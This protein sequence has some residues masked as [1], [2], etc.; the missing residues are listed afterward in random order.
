[1]AGADNSDHNSDHNSDMA[2]ND[3]L[4]GT[5]VPTITAG[6]TSPSAD[7]TDVSSSPVQEELVTDELLNWRAT[8]TA[9]ETIG[10]A[11]RWYL[12]PSNGQ[13]ELEYLG[14]EKPLGPV[15][16]TAN[17]YLG[18]LVSTEDI[19]PGWYW[20]VVCVSFK[21]VDLDKLDTLRL[22]TVIADDKLNMFTMARMCETILDKDEIQ[23]IPKDDFTRLRLHRQ[24]AVRVF[25]VDTHLAFELVANAGSN[26]S[27]P[28]PSFELHY[29]ELWASDY[30]P[31]DG[32]QDHVVYG[33]DIPDEIIRVGANCDTSISGPI[34][35]KAYDFSASGRHAATIYF[36][37]GRAHIEVWDLQQSKDRRVIGQPYR[38]LEPCARAS[39]PVSADITSPVANYHLDVMI[40]ISSSGSQVATTCIDKA[41]NHFPL[42]F[43]QSSPTA[44]AD[45]D[46]SL[47]W[48]LERVD[49]DCKG[50]VDYYGFGMFHTCDNENSQEENERFFTFEGTSFNVYSTNGAWIQL[51]SLEL[52]QAIDNWQPPAWALFQSLRGCY[53][54][55]TGNRGI[56]TIIDFD[57][58]TIVSNISIPEDNAQVYT[59]FSPDGSKVAISVKGTIQ[60]FDTF[61]GI[62]LGTYKEGLDDNNDFEVVLGHDQF[63]TVNS[64]DS[65]TGD[66]TIH[67]VRRV[68]RLSDMSVVSSHSVH[69]DYTLHFP[70]GDLKFACDQGATLSIKNMPSFDLNL[71]TVEE[72][73][74]GAS[75]ELEVLPFHITYQGWGETFKSSKDETFNLKIVHLFS[76]GDYVVTVNITSQ[77]SDRSA[78]AVLGPIEYDYHMF[79]IPRTSQIVFM[80]HQYLQ[81]WTLSD[82]NPDLCK[83]DYVWQ[84]DTN[85]PGSD[86]DFCRREFLDVRACQHSKQL[87]LTFSPAKWYRSNMEPVERRSM[88]P[89]ILTIPPSPEDTFKT[90]QEYRFSKGLLYIADSYVDSP[91][92]SK[93]VIVRYISSFIR[94]TPEHPTSS[95]LILCR[96][97]TPGGR[98]EFKQL[99]VDLLPTNVITWI[100]EVNI[101]KD[102]CPLAI[103]IE[104]AKS[105]PIVIEAAKVVMDYCVS[106]ANRFKNLVF[107][108]P[109]FDCMH[110]IMELYPNTALD[111]LARM[112]YIPVRHRSFIMDNHIIV[113]PPRVRLQFWKPTRKP[114][115][116]TKDPIMQLHVSSKV[117][118]PLNDKFTHPV[119]MAAFDALWIYQ[120][121]VTSSETKEEA[122]TKESEQV[123]TTWWKTLYHM[124]RLK[125]RLRTHTYVQ[126]HDFS[127]E[128]FDNPAIAALVAYKWNTIGF[129][130][131]LVRFC[132]QCCFYALVTIAALMQVYYEER[133][134]MVGL[135]IAIIV[136]GAVFLWLELLQAIRNWSRYSG[137]MY[138]FLDM[139]AYTIPITA[140]ID[141]LVLI[142]QNDAQG[143]TRLLSFSVLAIFL[144]MLFEMRIIKSVCKYVTIIQQS[145]IEIRAF[146]FIFAGGLVA[147]TIA[148]LHLLRACPVSEGCQEL[149]TN[150]SE[151]FLGAL[152]AIYFFMGGRYDPVN[153]E[154]DGQDWGFHIMMSIYFFFTVIVMLNVLIALI[155]V[156]FAKGDDGWRLAWI[157]S[158]LRYI[159]SAENMSYHIPGF[160][161]TYDWFPDEIYFT[162]PIQQ[163]RK[164]S[165]QRKEKAEEDEDMSF[166]K[167]WDDDDLD[168]LNEQNK[169][170]SPIIEDAGNEKKEDD[171]N[172]EKEEEK[173]EEKGEEKEEE[174]E[175]KEENEE[176]EEGS[177]EAAKDERDTNDVDVKEAENVKELKIQVAELQKELRLQREQSRK[178]F[179]ELKS[180]LLQ[181]KN[182]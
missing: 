64:T 72:T 24:I 87:K 166:L 129:T 73:C 36:T 40:D 159:E 82:T 174:E 137:T 148:T 10:A 105:K 146:F 85:E 140:S 74:N 68:V 37:P 157:E 29:L 131:W 14:A 75:C 47:P 23:R 83:L 54:A 139:V 122:K 135:F 8:M 58:G 171:S 55:W 133:S 53:F 84:F 41:E 160:R 94:P 178:E 110:D 79:Y 71:P 21:D 92:A 113:H 142:Y 156:A 35:V 69:Q 128:F 97:Y 119:F 31:S 77:S 44:P 78:T 89:D 164:Y 145:I 61:L 158:R 3:A 163:V 22:N 153:D 11:K 175:K 43:F 28:F 62:R 13:I 181:S 1:M 70:I 170:S 149:E 20:I 95:L 48:T 150:L 109:L 18:S 167:D 173:E 102:N 34:S 51:Y 165:K 80:G 120:D 67:N 99:L 65:T 49:R 27:E 115:Y 107:L 52:T 172:E 96:E 117:P 5:L 32:V 179:E 182:T 108:A 60:F 7:T 12:V 180:L 118:D 114:L 130:Y 98:D 26:N 59:S 4:S 123:T 88:E 177:G 126:C 121:I 90:T 155:N 162:A 19:T 104:A 144:H 56:V 66:P 16:M 93:R 106:H 125:C 103:L 15:T 154:F 124:I 17:Q 63:I 143:N 152:S 9:T 132:F 86:L 38:H 111:C 81:A 127:L 141:Q 50:L 169:Q 176:Q 134:Q 57:T 39:F 25:G 168:E 161:Q 151:N 45:K 33:S 116:Q 46:L 42:T 138:N 136:I 100:P 6:S 30:R 147:F 112:A 76:H 2:S 91:P 101:T